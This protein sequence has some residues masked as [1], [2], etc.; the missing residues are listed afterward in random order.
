MSFIQTIS[1]PSDVCFVL[2]VV[3]DTAC[4]HDRKEQLR[5]VF[6]STLENV[7]TRN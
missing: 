7:I 3:Y 4:K 2:A 1:H 6:R 5:H